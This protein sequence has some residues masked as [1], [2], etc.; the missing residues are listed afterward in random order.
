MD[1]ELNEPLPYWDWTQEDSDLPSLWSE[2]RN[3]VLT[4][5]LVLGIWLNIDLTH[6]SCKNTWHFTILPLV[7]DCHSNQGRSNVRVRLVTDRQYKL[8]RS[9]E[10]DL[11]ENS[12]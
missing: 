7:G 6:V 8:G 2:L 4:D 5:W 12:N 1:E 11:T 9:I 3:V 10:R